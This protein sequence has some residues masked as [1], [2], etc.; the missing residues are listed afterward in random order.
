MKWKL[1]TVSAGNRDFI[2]FVCHLKYYVNS[3]DL[4][5]CLDAGVPAATNATDVNECPENVDFNAGNRK[6]SCECVRK[7]PWAF[8]Y[9]CTAD[10]FSLCV[11]LCVAR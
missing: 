3:A 8:V 11:S 2:R 4:A 9:F 6:Y 7:L 1:A 10:V 5:L